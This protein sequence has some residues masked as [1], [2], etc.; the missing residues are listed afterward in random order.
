MMF[1]ARQWGTFTVDIYLLRAACVFNRNLFRRSSITK[2]LVEGLLFGG[3][4]FL[5]PCMLKVRGEVN[6]RVNVLAVNVATAGDNA[7]DF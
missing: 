4:D 1:M 2:F 5:L 6:V 7:H 3:G